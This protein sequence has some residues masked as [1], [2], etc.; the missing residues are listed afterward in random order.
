MFH[1]TKKWLRIQAIDEE[2]EY[3]TMEQFQDRVIKMLLNFPR[4]IIDKTIGSMAKRLEL[5]RD[6]RGK[7]IKY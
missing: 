1:L 3:E 2:I 5:V 7:R 4:E 6:G